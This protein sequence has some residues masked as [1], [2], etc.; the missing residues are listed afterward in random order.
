MA[1]V[2]ALGIDRIHL[3]DSLDLL[4]SVADS[5]AQLI[6]AAPPYN[7]GPRFGLEKMAA[8]VR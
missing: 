6:I 2:D 8:L 3:G 5:S 7:L 4:K 1:T